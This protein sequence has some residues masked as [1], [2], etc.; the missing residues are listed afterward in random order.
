MEGT[1][2]IKEDSGKGVESGEIERIKSVKHLPPEENIFPGTPAC[3]GCGALLSLRLSMKA[4]GRRIVIVNAA[5]CFTLLTIYPYTPFKNSWL[6]T[7]MACAPAGAQGIRDALDILI[8][9]GRLD[10]EEDL[11]VV[12]LTG[13]G[14]A[15]DIGLSSTSGALYRNLDFYYLCYDNEAYGNTGFQRS[16]ATP[17]ASKTGTTPPGIARPAGAELPK[18]DLFEIWRSHKPPY[19]ATISPAHPVDLINKF[20]RAEQYEGPKLFITLSPCPP[21]WATDPSYSVKLAKLAVDT[22]VWALKEAVYGEITHT[23]VPKRFKSV[24]EYLK[25]Q[26]RFAHLF[27]PVRQEETLQ[28]IQERVD[29]YWTRHQILL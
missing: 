12:V 28:K 13:D 6:Y 19:L 10:P 23:V 20:K 5:G 4:L 9:K 8:E 2:A 24:E 11:K 26:G 3:A 22:G 17:F 1:G 7:A 25:E 16:G 29:A 21:G 15:Y 18:K 27:K 14:A